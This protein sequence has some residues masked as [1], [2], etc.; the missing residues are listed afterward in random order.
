[1]T[2]T[3]DNFRPDSQPTPPTV[4][5]NAKENEHQYAKLRRSRRE[6]WQL[7]RRYVYPILVI[8]LLIFSLIPLQIYIVRLLGVCMVSL[9]NISFYDK[10]AVAETCTGDGVNSV[11][12]VFLSQILGFGG[13]FYCCMIYYPFYLA[14]PEVRVNKLVL[15][16]NRFA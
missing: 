5:E 8:P 2:A 3:S 4:C 12:F 6:T 1:M 10:I 11:G 16:L 7:W 9:N 13:P 15:F 14:Y